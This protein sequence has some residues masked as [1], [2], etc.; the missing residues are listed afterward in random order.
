M[1]RRIFQITSCAR[2]D[3]GTEVYAICNDGSTWELVNGA[4]VELPAIPQDASKD[5]VV[6][7]VS[8]RADMVL[9]LNKA[10]STMQLIAELARQYAESPGTASRS[11]F[12]R[13]VGARLQ[14]I[15]MFGR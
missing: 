15:L 12:M 9:R 2:P 8:E 13:E 3:G 4:W 10:E 6:K 7:L 5:P 14:K 1:I 11:T